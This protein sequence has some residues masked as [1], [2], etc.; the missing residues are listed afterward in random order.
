LCFLDLLAAGGKGPAA[1]GALRDAVAAEGGEVK[2]FPALTRERL[3]AWLV[4][5]A[6]SAGNEFGPGAARLLAERVG[7]YVREGDVDRRRQSEL[8]AAELDKLALY[9]PAGPI[10][11]DDVAA[12][13]PEAVPASAWAMLDAVGYRRAAPAATLVDRLLTDGTPLPVLISQLHRRL[14]ELIIVA[15]H[16]AAGSRPAD[17]VREM[18]LAPFRAQ[19]LSEQARGWTPAAL[20]AAL[21]GLLGLDLLS[22]GIAPDGGPR[23]LS[24]DRSRLALLGWIGSRVARAG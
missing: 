5:R 1:A 14:R 7:G 12:L 21:D 6:R 2:Q 24:D 17:I 8:A 3:E 23:S 18:G 19:K 11:R 4:E 20:E 10:S 16:L 9:R 22:K 15:E 13:V